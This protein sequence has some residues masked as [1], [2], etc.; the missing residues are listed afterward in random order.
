MYEAKKLNLLHD[1]RHSWPTKMFGRIGQHGQLNGPL[2]KFGFSFAKV[3]FMNQFWPKFI[4][5]T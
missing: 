5:K 3:D 2:L 1:G 4:N